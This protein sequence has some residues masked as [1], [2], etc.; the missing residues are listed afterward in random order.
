VRHYT[1]G[2]AGYAV[3]DW[4]TINQG[5][6]ANGGAVIVSAIDSN[7]SATTITPSAY[8]GCITD[9]DT[10]VATTDLYSVAANVP[11]TSGAPANCSVGEQTGTGSGLT[12][13]INAVGYNHPAVALF[14]YGMNDNGPLEYNTGE[15]MQGGIDAMNNAIQTIASAGADAVV[16]TSPHS[17]VVWSGTS[18]WTWNTQIPCGYA[19]FMSICDSSTFPNP[20]RVDATASVTTGDLAQTGTPITVSSRMIVINQEYRELATQNK[21]SCVDAESYWF[22]ALANQTAALGSQLAAE[23][24][25][26]T[27]AGPHPDLLGHQLSYQ[28]AIDD[29]LTALIPQ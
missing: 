14:V 10:F 3:G 7:G 4:V 28:R 12:V 16:L 2:R 24:E 27:V 9:A 19:Q 26:F 22:V 1:S 20:S 6:D 18:Q 17:S 11:T 21:V 8:P 25:L 15:S 29:F 5:N 23:Q 13:N